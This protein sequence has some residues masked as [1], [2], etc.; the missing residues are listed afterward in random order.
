M[1]VTLAHVVLFRPFDPRFSESEGSPCGANDPKDTVVPE[2]LFG[3]Y[4]VLNPA[5]V[6]KDC[7]DWLRSEKK[8]AQS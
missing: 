8:E 1:S 7:V 3:R 6:C 2:P 4:R 5:S